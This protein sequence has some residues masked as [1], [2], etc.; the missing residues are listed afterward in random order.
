MTAGPFNIQREFGRVATGIDR[1]VRY[2]LL[3]H[4]NLEW[5]KGMSCI[6]LAV[7]RDVQPLMPKALVGL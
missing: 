1:G 2:F 7:H 3:I 4:A 5:L 6:R